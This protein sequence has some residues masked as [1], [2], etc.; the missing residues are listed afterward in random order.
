MCGRT[1]E[2]GTTAAMTAAMTGMKA[3]ATTSTAA[4]MARAVATTNRAV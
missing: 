1:R 4:G 3:A 2:T